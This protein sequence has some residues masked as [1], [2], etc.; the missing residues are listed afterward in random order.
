MAWLPLQRGRA[1][2]TLVARSNARQI[3]PLVYELCALTEQIRIVEEATQLCREGPTRLCPDNDRPPIARTN[4]PR[5][6]N[7][8][9]GCPLQKRRRREKK[10]LS[11]T[12]PFESLSSAPTFPRRRRKG[13]SI[14]RAPAR[15]ESR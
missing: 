12:K 13:V 7:P 6:Y 2:I 4:R 8:R 10:V 15:Q 9:K 3:D 11:E 14:D 5:S 1:A